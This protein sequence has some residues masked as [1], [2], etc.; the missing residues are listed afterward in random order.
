MCCGEQ[1]KIMFGTIR[2]TFVQ[3]CSESY[4][5]NISSAKKSIINK[6]VRVESICHPFLPH[7][8]MVVQAFVQL[9][10]YGSL[11]YVREESF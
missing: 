8:A 3:N 10:H 11:F 2:G 1:G 5:R 7:T 9:N 4:V 6:D